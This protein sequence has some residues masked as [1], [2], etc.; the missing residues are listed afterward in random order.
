MQKNPNYLTENKI[1]AF[2]GQGVEVP[3]NAIDWNSMEATHYR[4]RQ[5]PGG[6]FNSLGFVRINIA[7]PYGVYMHDTP[8]KGIF[9]DDE[10]FVSSGCVRVQNV[11]DYVAWLLKENPGWDRDRIDATIRSGE[12]LTVRL[13]PPVPVYWVYITAWANEGIVQFRE[14]IYK[15]DGFGSGTVASVNGP[16]PGVSEAD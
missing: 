2:N 8:E 5:D 16:A 15:R 6:D 13:T 4:F 10:R 11:R 3:P 1:R 12:Q 14:D 9:G 7:N